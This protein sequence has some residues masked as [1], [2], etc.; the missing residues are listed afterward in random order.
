MQ[1]TLQV[2]RNDRTCT[3]LWATTHTCRTSWVSKINI[4]LQ[5]LFTYTLHYPSDTGSPHFPPTLTAYSFHLSSLITHELTI[6]P[7]LFFKFHLFML[8][9][10]RDQ[11]W[12]V[13]KDIEHCSSHHTNRKKKPVALLYSFYFSRCFFLYWFYLILSNFCYRTADFKWWKCSFMYI[14]ILYL[15]R[16]NT[17]TLWFQISISKGNLCVF[18]L[19][20]IHSLC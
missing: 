6:L 7:G 20:Y 13:C 5:S 8:M 14:S 19:V 4:F 18:T 2:C 10:I 15:Y 16:M 3:Y 12:T 11:C 9:T 1:K 17:K